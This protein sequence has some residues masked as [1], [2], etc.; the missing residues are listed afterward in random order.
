MCDDWLL[1]RTHYTDFLCGV[2]TKGSMALTRHRS[3]DTSSTESMSE[4]GSGSNSN[5]GGNEYFASVY[6]SR[7]EFKLQKSRKKTVYSSYSGING[8]KIEYDPPQ[9]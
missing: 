3:D 5:F 8:T 6:F 9:N 2:E 7:M 4:N 1:L